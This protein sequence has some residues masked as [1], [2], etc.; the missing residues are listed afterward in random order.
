MRLRLLLPLL[1][2]LSAC[3]SAPSR[4]Y[5]LTAE[6]GAARPARSAG[7]TVA[8]VRVE[9]P[10][11]LDRPE[12]ARRRGPNRIDYAEDERWAGPLDAMVRR[13]LAAD[14]ATR[15]PAGMTLVET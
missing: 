14:L 11:A 13:V 6:P 4:F 10:G 12:L 7:T 3:H 9:L 8:L 1:A 2:V 5:E 15:L